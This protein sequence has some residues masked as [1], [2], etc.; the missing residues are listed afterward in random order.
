V[1]VRAG[2]QAK[3]AAG[4]GWTIV[5]W[6]A[7]VRCCTCVCDACQGRPRLG[8][9]RTATSTIMADNWVLS[10]THL[11]D[12]PKSEVALETLQRIAKLVKPIMRKH[13]WKLPVLS[14]F[15][16]AEQNLVG[17]NGMLVSVLSLS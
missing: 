4:D 1:H 6:W 15:F 9:P 5:V 12:R 8:L 14:E 3:E 2:R 17:A 16:P 11:K 7:R 13:S 10:F